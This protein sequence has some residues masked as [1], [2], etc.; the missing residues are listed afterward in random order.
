MCV[1]SFNIQSVPIS[2]PAAGEMSP[3]SQSVFQTAMLKNEI[4]VLLW[5][6]YIGIF[7]N[8]SVVYL[9]I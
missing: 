4:G 1:F 3:Q 6:L 7:Y 5:K 2:T 8:L 9:I